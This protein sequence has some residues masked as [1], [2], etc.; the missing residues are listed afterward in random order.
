MTTS[1]VP[2]AINE[3][4]TTMCRDRIAT[5]PNA[6]AAL[7][8]NGMPSHMGAALVMPAANEQAVVTTNHVILGRMM[9]LGGLISPAIVVTHMSIRNPKA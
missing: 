2:T 6:I 9:L 8:T 5:A 7:T 3:T 1:V 4:A